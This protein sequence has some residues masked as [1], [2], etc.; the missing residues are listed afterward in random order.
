MMAVDMTPEE[1][2]QQDTDAKVLLGGNASQNPPLEEVQEMIET[3]SIK[4]A[5]AS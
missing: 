2:I 1:H 3:L 5:R 4:C